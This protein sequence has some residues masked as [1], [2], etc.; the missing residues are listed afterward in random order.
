VTN[1]QDDI[2][3]RGSVDDQTIQ[4]FDR[5]DKNLT[6]IA[7]AAEKTFKTVDS[8]SKRSGVA[9]G[10]LAGVAA[11]VTG[12]LVNMGLQ[13][14]NALKSFVGQ[15]VGLR[16]RVDTLGVTLNL[17][18]QKAGYTAEQIEA[19]EEELKG[20]GIT[21]QAA[22]QSLLLMTRANIDWS[23]AAI[24]AR[25]AQDAAVV[26]GL[27]SSQAFERL[28][29]GIQK[30]E[31]ELL[32]ELGLTIN[33]TRAYEDLAKTLDKSSKEL[34]QAE[35]SQAILNQI[36]QQSG[37]V[38][39]SYEASLGTVGKQVTSLPRYIEELQLAIGGI[40]QPAYQAQVEFY[41][42]SLKKIHTWFQENQEQ[43]TEFAEDLGVLAQ[44]L[45]DILE[46]VV[47]FAINLPG[48]IKNA[49]VNLAEA[50]NSLTKHMSDEELQSS[51]GKLG[52]TFKQAL[53]I[54]VVGAAAAVE[55][56]KQ[57]AIAVYE[58]GSA[59]GNQIIGL[60]D[61]AQAAQKA[62]RLDF[63]GAKAEIAEFQ[64]RQAE[65]KKNLEEFGAVA[66]GMG[67]KVMAA[68]KVASDGMLNFLY[69]TEEV[70]AAPPVDS[71]IPADD[72]QDDSESSVEALEDVNEA[73]KDLH[74]RWQ[75]EDFQD[76][77]KEQRRQIEDAIRLRHRME[78]IERGH[79]ERISEIR[80]SYQEQLG[81]NA[82]QADE[83]RLDLE[84][85]H[86]E[87]RLQVEQDYQIRLQQIQQDFDRQATEL[88]R[89]RDAVRL[90]ALMRD[91]DI[92][93]A[94]A[95]Q[96]YEENKAAEEA[97]Y[98]EQLTALQENLRE[99]EMELSES[100]REQLAEA[101]EA[102]AKELENLNRQLER[103]R[104]L[105]ELHRKWD[106]EDR[107]REHAKQLEQLA[108]QFSQ[109]EGLT[110]EGLRAV[111]D[112]WEA[113]LGDLDVIY[114][115]Y[116]AI[117]QNMAAAAALA[118]PGGLP[119][120]GGGNAPGF[121]PRY[122]G[123]AFRSSGFAP[124]DGFGHGVTPGGHV[125]GQGGQV[126]HT[127]ASMGDHPMMQGYSP[128][129]PMIPPTL[130]STSGTQ[131]KEIVVRVEGNALDPYFQRLLVNTLT[132]VERNANT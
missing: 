38:A 72:I 130:P 80:E 34:T 105:R 122:G 28:I 70:A 12:A 129:V 108:E 75:E 106:E 58:L 102:R 100:L 128:M 71:P 32:D 56:I 11:G 13:A 29:R 46:R 8:G 15:A 67:E 126:S 54:I 64:A 33:R 35:R 84:Q 85:Q 2:L 116:L 43:V 90:L 16:A 110:A 123:A 81:E 41:T 69:A 74:E 117:Q 76:A 114:Q 88:A 61:L 52:E 77:L 131:R 39:G 125:F 60:N 82:Q 53:Y 26:A 112:Q 113:Y 49:G 101:E 93:L 66:D 79:L 51:A 25:I 83:D 115:E 1:K 17:V 96:E 23:Q 132:E 5:F 78:D 10:A 87:A 63:S 104:E 6:R 120:L 44:K 98:A 119:V 95:Q 20:L 99:Q 19:T 40:F 9:L 59:V 45:F 94:D 3:F 7:D 111:L 62:A 18:G 107:A 42:E 48:H 31:P 91:K 21:T 73:L 124:T 118:A 24:L 92:E 47:E 97:R 4:F 86:A 22:R 50:I 65:V 27:N 121:V 127:L 30:G 68:A 14:A 89:S 55:G 36:I 103:E 109:M 37:V 57:L